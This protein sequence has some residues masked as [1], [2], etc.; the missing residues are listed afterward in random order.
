MYIIFV[1]FFIVSRAVV[2]KFI[3]EF[4]SI[5]LFT[6]YRCSFSPFFVASNS[7]KSI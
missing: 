7:R 2:I 5:F 3:F 6:D 1:P 4:Q